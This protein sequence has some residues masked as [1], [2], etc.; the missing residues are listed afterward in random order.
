MKACNFI[1]L[2]HIRSLSTEIIST[3][4]FITTEACIRNAIIIISSVSPTLTLSYLGHP[5]IETTHK[6]KLTNL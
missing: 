5:L 4:K 1:K 6:L 3:A 2:A